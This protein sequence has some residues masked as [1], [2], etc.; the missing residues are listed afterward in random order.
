MKL[1][2]EYENLDAVGDFFVVESDELETKIK[3][4]IGYTEELGKYWQGD[5]YDVYKNNSISNL[6]NITNTS[7]EFNAYGNA[8]KKI[9]KIYGELDNDFSIKLRRMNK[10]E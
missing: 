1:K 3:E 9:S 5:D 8:L 7:I 4:L 6:Q 2:S 10:Y